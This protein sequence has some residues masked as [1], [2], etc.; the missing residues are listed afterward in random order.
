MTASSASLSTSFSLTNTAGAAANIA[1][2]SAFLGDETL[3]ELQNGHWFHLCTSEAEGWGHYIAEA[4]SV[5]AVTFTC[6]AP[7]MNELVSA[8]RGVLVPAPAGER[9][10]LATLCHFDPAALEAAIT[11]VLAM[12]PTQWEGIGAAA[13]AWFL[14]NKHGFTARVRGALSELATSTDTGAQGGRRP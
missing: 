5:G 6:D 3:C 4:M 2:H 1:H 13:R 12:A 9:H 11:R 7:P 8:D 14:Q 10:N